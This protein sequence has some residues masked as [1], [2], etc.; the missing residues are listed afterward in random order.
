MVHE[1]T[2]PTSTS[3]RNF[4]MKSWSYTIVLV[5]AWTQIATLYGYWHCRGLD[6]SGRGVAQ[7]LE[8]PMQ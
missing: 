3:N 7:D 1:A 8:K 6:P 2:T 4:W 5:I